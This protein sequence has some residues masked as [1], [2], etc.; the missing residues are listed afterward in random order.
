VP[1]TPDYVIR[2]GDILMLVADEAA[3]ER[4]LAAH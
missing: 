2:A 4:F 3:M 1:A